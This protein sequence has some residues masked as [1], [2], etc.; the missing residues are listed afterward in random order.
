MERVVKNSI[1]K[2]K[3][4]PFNGQAVDLWIS[5]GKIAGIG[6]EYPEDAEVFDGS[7]LQV[8]PGWTDGGTHFKDPGYEWLDDLNSI[9]EAAAFGGFTRV[10]GF[11][12][13][14][15]V[16]QTKEAIAYF[17]HFNRSR[18]VQLL[19]LAAVTRGCKG[20]DFTDMIDLKMGGAV[21]FSDGKEA[22]QNSDIFLKTL[23]Y[24]APL[25]AVLVVKSEDKYLSM[26]GQMHEGVSS[27]LLGMK[28]IPS[29]AEEL[30]IVRNLKLLEYSGVKS[31]W[32][33]LHFSTLS[34]RGAV[35]LIRE[36][37]AKG[38]PVSCDIAAHQLAFTDE[39]LM[40][41]DTVYK[42]YPPFRSADDIA[43]LKEGLVDG[44]IDMV[45]SDHNSWDAE[46]KTLEFDA[47]EFGAVG[48]QTVFSV[49]LEHLGLEKT[50]EKLVYNPRKIFRLEQNS[51]AVGQ[52]ADFTLFS[53]EEDYICTEEW[54]K[55]KGKNTPFLGKSLRGRAKAVCY[56]G[57]FKSL[58]A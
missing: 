37:K 31:E 54:L 52:T 42:V 51:I 11:P 33:V 44:T 36:A 22:L 13:T 34:T 28:G 29:A 55:S 46:H 6:S 18:P 15:P 57:Q 10:I 24:L 48:L 8:S 50:L 14:Q 39:D 25:N 17:G 19:N 12:N 47:A 3:N 23:Q 40:S 26:Y 27:T 45:V 7:G 16:V 32:P 20:E 41:F 35:D 5:G 49:C 38:L 4:S 21:G 1:V 56:G 2:D 58:E 43:A 53:T 30:M 9:H